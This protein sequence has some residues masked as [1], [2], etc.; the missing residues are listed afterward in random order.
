[1]THELLKVYREVS[2]VQNTCHQHGWGLQ[3][4]H[5]HGMWTSKIWICSHGSLYFLL[6]G[7]C[8]PALNFAAHIIK[9]HWSKAGLFSCPGIQHS[10][11][12]RL[13]YFLLWKD[14]F[15]KQV[16]PK[17]VLMQIARQ[18]KRMCPRLF[19]QCP[20]IASPGLPSPSSPSE[21]SQPNDPERKV[22]IPRSQA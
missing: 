14:W 5:P 10:P 1:M 8:Y 9:A 2:V 12:Q 22:A 19:L 18:G 13:W 20:S 6:V 15:S 7:R 21:R 17:R 16:Y 4:C 11:Q 3:S